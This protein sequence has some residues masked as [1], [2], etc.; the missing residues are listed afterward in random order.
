MSKEEVQEK[1]DPKLYIE[2]ADEIKVAAVAIHNPAKGKIP[3]FVCAGQSQSINISSRFNKHVTRICID[4]CKYQERTELES[5][6]DYGVRCDIIFINSAQCDFLLGE[7]FHVGLV[8]INYNGKNFCY[9]FLGGSSAVMMRHHVIDT[10]MFRITNMCRYLWHDKDFASDILGLTF[11]SPD[12]VEN[13]L[14]WLTKTRVKLL[15]FVLHF[16]CLRSRLFAVN[17]TILGFCERVT[18]LLPL[19]NWITLLYYRSTLGSNY[20]TMVANVRNIITETISFFFL[21]VC[22][23]IFNPRYYTTEPF[24]NTSGGWRSQNNRGYCS[25]MCWAWG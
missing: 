22:Y 25:V 8:D 11:S 14:L 12:T 3:F 7:I 21:L 18:F 17:R 15:S 2:W 13:Y 20:S 1:L 10:R 9:Q 24:E 5:V 19:M 16:Y 23:D 6:A 4:V